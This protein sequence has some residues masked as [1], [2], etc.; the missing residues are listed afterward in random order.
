[1]DSEELLGRLARLA[2]LVPRYTDQ[3]GTLRVASLEGQRRC[4][5]AMGLDLSSPTAIDEAIRSFRHPSPHALHVVAEGNNPRLSGLSELPA[6]IAIRLEDGAPRTARLTS[7]GEILP[8]HPLP[9]G[10]HEMT[11][12][13]WRHPLHLAVTPALSYHPQWI[14]R[15]ESRWGL[16]THVYALGGRGPLGLFSDLARL[17][18]GVAAAGG[19]GVLIN[20]ICAGFLDRPEVKSPY[21]PSDRRG[22]N[23]LYI[24]VHAA[25]REFGVYLKWDEAPAG[26][27][28]DY[29]TAAASQLAGLRALA[30]AAPGLVKTA[31]S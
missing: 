6:T 29:P 27:G 30:A 19:D 15:Q 21:Q 22:L 25:A 13:G 24:D 18:E 31:V 20:P 14:L 7:T 23:P 4:L 3:R 8:E 2:G 12:P 28:I 5:E 9:I 11:A 1:M 26:A 17:L 16:A 10:Y